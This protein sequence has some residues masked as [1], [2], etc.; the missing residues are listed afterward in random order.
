MTTMTR[1]WCLCSLSQL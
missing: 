1:N